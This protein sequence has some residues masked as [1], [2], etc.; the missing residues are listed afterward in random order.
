LVIAND[1]A[2]EPDGEH[3]TLAGKNPHTWHPPEDCPV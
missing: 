3:S 2:G 1:E